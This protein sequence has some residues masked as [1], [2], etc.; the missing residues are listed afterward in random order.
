ML[1]R[2]DR[3]KVEMIRGAQSIK[4]IVNEGLDGYLLIES[5]PNKIKN[6]KKLAHEMAI[7]WQDYLNVPAEGLKG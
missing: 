6:I 2:A 5:K 7:A 3:T 4:V 1:S